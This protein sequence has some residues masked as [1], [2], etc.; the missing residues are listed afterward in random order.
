MSEKPERTCGTCAE[1]YSLHNK[2]PFDKYYIWAAYCGPAF[3]P[4]APREETDATLCTSYKE[5]QICSAG[6]ESH[7]D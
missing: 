2:C 6:P 7:D 5:R 1:F 4:L 3:D